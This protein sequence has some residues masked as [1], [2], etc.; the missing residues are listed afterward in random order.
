MAITSYVAQL[1]SVQAAIEAIETG[2]QSYSITTASGSRSMSRSDLNTLYERE[3]YL[4]SMVA[5]EQRGGRRMTG[6]TP[7]NN[8]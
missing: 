2:A 5:T 3:K 4:R 6:L 7:V 8:A 1:E